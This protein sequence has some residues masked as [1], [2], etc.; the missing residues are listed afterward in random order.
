MKNAKRTRKAIKMAIAV[1]ATLTTLVAFGCMRVSNGVVYIQSAALPQGWPELT[2]V[3]TVEVKT[4]PLYRAAIVE[5]VDI[6]GTGEEP[7]FREL[8]QHIKANDIAMTAPVTMEY[9]TNGS[10]P[11]MS[12]MAFLYRKPD[13]G[14]VGKDGNVT[15][16]D[17]AA[18]TFATVG[19]RG[20][21]NDRN[22]SR[23]LTQLRTWLEG[24]DEFKAAGSPRYLG[25]NGPFVPK[26]ARYGE[27]QIPVTNITTDTDAT[28]NP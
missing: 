15:V 24:S 21:Y 28:T 23:G 4:Y 9:E 26:I 1:L 8:F 25:Y 10:A 22:F 19:V 11:E 6:A 18:A 7:M 5:D 12:S 3:G 27:V 20:D 14:T 2:P 17:L 16:Q 13:L